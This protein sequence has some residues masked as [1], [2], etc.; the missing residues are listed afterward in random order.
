MSESPI[1]S[2]QN[3]RIKDTVKLRQRRIREEKHQTVIDGVREI[4][5]A[6]EAGVQPLEAFVC[7]AL[8]DGRDAIKLVENISSQG[9]QISEV[10]APVFE[11]LAFGDRAEG[12]VAVISIPQAGLSDLQ[13]PQKPVIGIIEGV[14]K[15]G[16]LGAILR[17]ADAAGV[18]ALV[19][20]DG[21]TDLF[22]PAVIRASLG[23]I[24]TVPTCTATSS[25]TLAWLNSEKIPILAARPDGTVLHTE[26]DMTRG[27]AIVLGSEADGLSDTWLGDDI[28]PIR[29]PMHGAAD[30]LNVSA[31]AAVLF[32][33]ALRQK[34]Q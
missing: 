6:I 2:R 27:A 33:E 28:Q 34:S 24:F 18:G 7:Q 13:L 21:R 25:E 9:C 31:T 1:T 10:T 17:S 26:T 29:L 5:R 3:Q 32:Y 12:I 22:N 19:V 23:T 8:L 30:S 16:N 14:E 20:A 4:S 11:K 15:P